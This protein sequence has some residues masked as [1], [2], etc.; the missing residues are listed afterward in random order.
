MC[1]SPAVEPVIELLVVELDGKSAVFREQLADILVLQQTEKV[2]TVRGIHFMK[3]TFFVHE[4]E[5]KL[6]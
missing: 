6:N 5:L 4:I 2:Q 1:V 3:G